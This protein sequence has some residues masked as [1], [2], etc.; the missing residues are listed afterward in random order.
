MAKNWKSVV[1]RDREVEN[2]FSDWT[3]RQTKNSEK[4]ETV[5]NTWKERD[6]FGATIRKLREAFYTINKGRAFDEILEEKL[7][8]R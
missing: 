4:V 7:V 1:V 2:I 8:L 6:G 5:I 3:G